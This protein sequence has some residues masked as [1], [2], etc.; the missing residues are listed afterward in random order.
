MDKNIWH[1][2]LQ[3]LPSA[4]H[5]RAIRYKSKQSSYNFIAG[6]LLLMHGLRKQGLD[7][8]LKNLVVQENGKPLIPDVYFNIS[9]TAHQVVCA[10]ANEAN[11]GVDIEMIKEIDFNDFTTMFSDREWTTIKDS[12]DPLKRFYWFWTRKESI[13]KALGK[14]LNFL[15]QIELDVTLD[16]FLVE[17]QKWYLKELDLGKGYAGAICCK[18]EI[19][20]VNFIKVN[21]QSTS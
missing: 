1:Q 18:A 13:I 14:N 20:E 11:L 15:H 10:F 19:K 6:R 16:H 5:P 12:S 8:S 2:L 9:H 4:S 17:G 3:S 21:L 7:D